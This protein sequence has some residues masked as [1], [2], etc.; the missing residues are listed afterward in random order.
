MENNYKYDT[1]V[2]MGGERWDCNDY[3]MLEIITT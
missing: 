3:K 1:S 2:E